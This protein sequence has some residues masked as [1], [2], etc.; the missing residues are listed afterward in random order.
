M[1]QQPADAEEFAPLSAGWRGLGS[2]EPDAFATVAITHYADDR[3]FGY[4]LKGSL[5][6]QFCRS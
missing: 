5:T 4:S 6:G 3:A 2:D 1:E